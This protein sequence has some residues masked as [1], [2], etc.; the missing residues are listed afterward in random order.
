[1]NLVEQLRPKR[2]ELVVAAEKIAADM[3]KPG[4]DQSIKKSQL[5]HLIGV[6]GEATCAEEI[7][8]YVRYQAGR[9]N[10]GWTPALAKEVIAG[11]AGALATLDNDRV[12]VEAWR[13]YTVFLTR[14]F[15]FQFAASKDRPA[16][17]A[18]AARTDKQPQPQAQRGR[19]R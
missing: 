18:E 17:G 1:M 15:T 10:T 3:F 2:K 11:I 7:E 19:G 6:C 8:N 4:Q 12:R 9:K 13:I 14:A 5:N 16:A